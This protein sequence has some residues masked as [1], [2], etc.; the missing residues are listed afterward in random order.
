MAEIVFILVEPAVPGN[1]GA[2]ARAMKTMGYNDLRLINPADHLNE[3]ARKLAHGSHE[4]LFNAKIFSN[5]EK[6][7]EDIDFVVGTSAKHRK[8]KFDYFPIVEIPSLILSKS[9]L[10]QKAAL[11]FGR[12][13][14]GL[15]NEEM[16]LCDVMAYIPMLTTYP[17]LNLSQA[18]MLSAYEM[19]RAFESKPKI[20]EEDITENSFKIIRAKTEEMLNKMGVKE[21]QVLYGRIMERIRLLTKDDL[22]LIHSIHKY[23]IGEKE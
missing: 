16:A 20:I 21:N 17:S 4:V 5:L 13:E 11:I 14:S 18:V 8:V 12:E 7:L 9:N 3:D 2:S 22:N 1:I 10:I 6:A 19:S 23:F 15:T